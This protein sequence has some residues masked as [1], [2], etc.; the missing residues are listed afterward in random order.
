MRLANT[1]GD[2]PLSR[3][4]F[5]AK[6]EYEFIANFKILQ[7]CFNKHKIDKMYANS[8]AFE[9]FVVET[10]PTIDQ[11]PLPV[12]RL[13]KMRFQDNFEF[14]QWL[15][16]FW[17]TYCPGGQ[18]DAVGRRRG[19]SVDVGGAVR[20]GSAARV[21]SAGMTRRVGD[22]PASRTLRNGPGARAPSATGS[23]GSR[24]GLAGDAKAAGM[25]Q[26]LTREVAE[27]KETIIGIEK[28]RDFYFDKLRQVEIM[29]QQIEPELT[30]QELPLVRDIQAV[31]YSTEEG[32]VLQGDEADAAA[33]E[34][35]MQKVELDEDETF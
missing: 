23:A 30:E 20:P 6:Q 19:Q 29:I 12:E 26:E 22:R 17:E 10:S 16:R 8:S 31:L 11:Q 27:L 33:V 24:G 14:L 9:T 15:K 4:K 7:N 32:F 35:Q 3:V 1:T 34:Q 13:I 25:V 5:N 2:L 21:P 28:E 18:Y